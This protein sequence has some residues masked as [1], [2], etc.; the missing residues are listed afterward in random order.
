MQ[1]YAK[2]DHPSHKDFNKLIKSYLIRKLPV[3]LEDTIRA[4]KIYGPNITILKGNITQSKLDTVV[5][6]YI[7]VPK[8]II[9]ANKIITVIEDIIFVNKIPLL[10]TII[11]NKNLDTNKCISNRTMKQIT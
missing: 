7:K 3:T 5:T 2:V 6:E 8:D 11:H 9:K 1:L 4:E 10:V